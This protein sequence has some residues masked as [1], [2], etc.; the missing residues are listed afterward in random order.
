MIPEIEA[1]T[2]YKYTDNRSDYPAAVW[3][4]W[5]ALRG[6]A[7]TPIDIKSG[8]AGVTIDKSKGYFDITVSSTTTAGW[9][10]GTYKYVIYMSK[11]GENHQVETGTVEVKPNFAALTLTD[12]TRSHVKR[13]LDAI[14]AVIEKRAT[15]DQ[16]SYSLA[17]RSLSRT[18]IEDLIKFRDIYRAE[19]ARELRAEKIA[20]GLGTN[21]KIKVRF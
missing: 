13:V 12:D 4:I 8:V 14:E 18:P 1:G 19:Y 3:D 21:R 2:T 20:Q 5:I 6:N 10:A 17:G 9:A 15:L 11:T 16:M 7:V